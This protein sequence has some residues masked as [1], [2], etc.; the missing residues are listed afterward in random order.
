MR[1]LAALSVGIVITAAL[2]ADVGFT[3]T[4]VANGA[5][6]L[7]FLI[8]GVLVSLFIVR[9]PGISVRTSRLAGSWLSRW[10]GGC[11][12]SLRDSL[13]SEGGRSPST[14]R[15]TLADAAELIRPTDNGD[16]PEVIVMVLP[17]LKM[18]I[19]PV[20]PAQCAAAS[21]TVVPAMCSMPS[22]CR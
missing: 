22:R 18:A 3:D 1:T 5:S 9:R 10:F 16:Q 14:R 17:M 19:S 13:P 11:S 7:A 6:G 2:I 20:G 21:A 15:T 8:P 4:A 12:F